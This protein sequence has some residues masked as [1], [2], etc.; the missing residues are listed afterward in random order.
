MKAIEILSESKK[1]D[2]APAS[3]LGQIARRAGAG[4]LSAVGLNTWAKGLDDKADVGMFANRYY[5]EFNNYLK[6]RNRDP[7]RAT[8]GDLKSFM[9]KNKIPTHNVPSNPSGAATKSMVT[10]ILSQTAQ[11][12]T[13]GK[14]P[15]GGSNTGTPQSNTTGKS[16]TSTTGQQ[17]T[18]GTTST[19]A[20]SGNTPV[21]AAK[22]KS[23]IGA[24]VQQISQMSPADLAKVEKAIRRAQGTTPAAPAQDNRTPAEIRAAKQKTAADN[25][26]AQMAQNSKTAASAPATQ[27]PA[28]V[29]ASKQAAA[30]QTAQAQMTAPPQTTAAAPKKRR[31]SRPAVTPSV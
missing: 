8:Y 23:N 5:K 13:S 6:G 15:G 20:Q 9:T 17:Q 26:Q 31:R 29:R 3:M 11:E 16:Q 7:E 27:T 28:D 2:E 10:S 24:I 30:A 19:T 14:V 4:V 12:V 21:P 25:A 22:P 18:S 1:I